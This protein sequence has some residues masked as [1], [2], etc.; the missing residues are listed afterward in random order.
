MVWN[1]LKFLVPLIRPNWGQ[2]KTLISVTFSFLSI[3]MLKK[4][5]MNQFFLEILLINH[6]YNFTVQK[7]KF[8]IKNFFSKCDQILSK[9]PIWSHLLTKSLMKN[10]IILCS[11]PSQCE[12]FFWRRK[13]GKLSFL[14]VEVSQEGNYFVITVYRKPT[15]TGAFTHFDRFLPTTHKF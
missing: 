1:D 6:S 15:F 11:V 3:S 10:F 2:P 8:S 14:D 7:I 4:K 9:L 5:M 13:S 12:I